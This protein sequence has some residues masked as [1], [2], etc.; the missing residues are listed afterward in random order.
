VLYGADLDK[1]KKI[2]LESLDSDERILKQPAPII[3]F[4]ELKYSIIDLHIYFWLVQVKDW[5]YFRSD[6][7]QEIDRIFKENEI[8]MPLPPA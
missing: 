8:A 1:V 4:A 3:E 5:E 6:V 7:I 2:L